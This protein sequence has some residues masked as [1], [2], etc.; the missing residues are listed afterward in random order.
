MFWGYLYIEVGTRLLG[1]KVYA[2][3][4][5]LGLDISKLGIRGDFLKIDSSKLKE[6]LLKVFWHVLRF[7]NMY[8][9]GV[10]G[11]MYIY[12]TDKNGIDMKSQKDT[13]IV[14]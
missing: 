2:L 11:G 5:T 3:S 6:K 13:L 14:R 12:C 9:T 4:Q 1:N 10:S 7:Y 8:C